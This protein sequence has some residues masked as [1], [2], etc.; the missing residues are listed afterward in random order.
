M[1]LKEVREALVRKHMSMEEEHDFEGAFDTFHHARYEVVPTGD[2]FDGQA[3][4]M[5]FYRETDVAFPDFAFDKVVLHHAED[6]V[7]VEVDFVG[8]H[9][10]AWRGLPATGAKVRYR[11]CNVF[12]F[13]G[14]HLVCERL[15]FDLHGLLQQLGIA[16][17]PTTLAGRLNTFASHPLTVA[18]AFVRQL[19][20]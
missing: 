18:R 14:E 12:E 7:I 10:G 4:V 19:I 3:E 13:D 6:S 9:M 2:T 5:Q 16:R 11:M 8:T 1:S 17:D 20:N 15:Y